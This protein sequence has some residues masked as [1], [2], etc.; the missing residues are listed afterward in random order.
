[1]VVASVGS[2][3]EPADA[4]TVSADLYDRERERL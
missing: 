3:A 1:M 4:G 2:R